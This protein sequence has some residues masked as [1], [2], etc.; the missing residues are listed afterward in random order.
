MTTYT[1]PPRP[2]SEAELGFQR[3]RPVQWFA[4]SVL[5]RAGM[6]VVLSAAFGDYLDK[7]ELQLSLGDWVFTDGMQDDEAWIDVIADTGDGFD[8]TYTV[9]WCAS[10]PTLRP[11]GANRDLPRGGYLILAGDEVYP[12]G[13]PREY[14]DRF[15]GPYK[16]ALPWTSTDHPRM[17]AIPGNHDWYDGLTG[18]M[19]VFGQERWIGG[20][21]TGQHRSYFAVGLP[22]RHWLWGIDIQND[23]YV[24]AAQISYFRKASGFMQP[25]DRLILCSAKPSWTDNDDPDAYRNLEFVERQLV[26]KGVDTV[27]M[28]SGD[29]HHYAHYTNVSDEGQARA[30]LTAG[31]GGAFLSATHTLPKHVDVPKSVLGEDDPRDALE[32]FDLVDPTFPSESRS[33]RLTFGA[34]GLGLRNPTFVLVTAVL[35]LLLFAANA[36]G[37][38]PD[39]G[40]LDDVA[41]TWSYGDL[42]TGNFRGSLS[43]VLVLILFCL[44]A[45]FYKVRKSTP[46]WLGWI[47]R[48]VAGA[49]HT[50]AQVLAHGL[51]ALW[52]I[53]IVDAIGVEGIWFTVAVSALV[54]L[55]GGVFGSVVFGAYLV[56]ALGVFGRHANEAFSAARYEGYKNLLRL[57]VTQDG[58]TVYAIGIERACHDWEIDGQPV[59]DEASYLRPTSGSIATEL[60]EPPFTI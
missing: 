54:F 23:A 34:L 24:D 1:P 2:A 53:S 58:V 38:R 30:K 28:I 29:K 39:E 48:I 4:P 56:I 17:L 52:S 57:H 33:R 45:A 46:A 40:T 41:P 11:E 9:A 16:A 59:S 26:A 5:A 51:V 20:R 55:L 50:A 32:R 27:L 36:A 12:V 44:L 14:E 60:I 8:P 13:S 19:R 25:G 10:Q 47:Q 18:F 43:V 3:R 22:H 49:A 7:R 35:N 21:R 31:G 15:I 37:L 6:K 42:L